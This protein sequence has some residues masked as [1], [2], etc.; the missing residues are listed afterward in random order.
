METPIGNLPAEGSLDVEGLD[1]SREDL[2][3][4]LRVD[5]EGWLAEARLVSEYYDQFGRRVPQALRQE[6]EA[7]EQRLEAARG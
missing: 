3:E 1:L 7:L 6:L 5:L 2:A 4:L